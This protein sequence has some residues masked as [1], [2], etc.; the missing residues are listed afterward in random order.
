MDRSWCVPQISERVHLHR[1]HFRER[2]SDTLQSFLRSLHS[3][4]TQISDQSS[5]C[6][7]KTG[8]Y[9]H[10]QRSTDQVWIFHLMQY[11]SFLSEKF[12]ATSLWHSIHSQWWIY[13]SSWSSSDLSYFSF[14]SSKGF[15]N[16]SRAFALTQ[17][18]RSRSLQYRSDSL[19]HY[20]LSESI[21]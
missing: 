10:H 16:R 4:R 11:S 20:L 7:S 14:L 19:L 18:L 21:A 2:S 5:F 1:S 3:A 8:L 12:R 17:Y 6:L 15:R 13:L 9:Q